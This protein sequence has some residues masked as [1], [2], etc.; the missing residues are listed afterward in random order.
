M[1]A[2]L[3]DTATVE[4]RYE[5]TNMHSRFP[6]CLC[7]GHTEKEAVIAVLVKHCPDGAAE[8]LGDICRECVNARA[9]ADIRWPAAAFDDIDRAASRID[10]DGAL[11]R[12]LETYAGQLTWD[13]EFVR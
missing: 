10:S 5:L 9:Q 3:Q 11:D 8:N 6:C 12:F 7:A 13:L 2:T 1:P 4:V